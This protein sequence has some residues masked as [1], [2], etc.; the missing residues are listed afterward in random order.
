MFFCDQEWA[1]EGYQLWIVCD[2]GDQS[3]ADGMENSHDTQ[4]DHMDNGHS[5]ESTRV[6]QL[7]FVKSALTV[8]PCSVCIAS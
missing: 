7:Q 4:E 5:S 8:N 3:L 2:K 1:L 6:M